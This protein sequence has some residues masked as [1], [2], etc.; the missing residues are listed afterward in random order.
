MSTVLVTGGTGALGTQLVPRL[1]AAGHEVRV[2]SRKDSPSLPSG[3]TAVKGNL[4]TGDG[5]T[6]AVSGVDVIAHLAS[7]SDKFPTYK[8]A[9]RTDVDGTKRLV[10]AAAGTRPHLVYISIVGI[11]V[12]PMGYY[13]AKLETERVIER[14]GLPYTILRT[15]QWH[16]LAASFGDRFAKSPIVVLPKGFSMQL[17]DP[18]EVAE[19]MAALVAGPPRGHVDD[20]GGPHVISTADAMRRYLNAKG[21]KRAVIELPLPGKLVASLRDGGNLTRQHADG[22]IT[23]DDWL[24]KNVRAT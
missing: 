11:D 14:S 19:R 15:T 22:K 20:M 24:A 1:V 17:L 8:R 12:V 13:K 4:D 9:K 5:L 3:V 2:L 23:F 21:T 16:T 6:A 10:D 18:G 7:G